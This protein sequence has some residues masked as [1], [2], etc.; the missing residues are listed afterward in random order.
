[1]GAHDYG[2]SRWPGMQI[3]EAPALKSAPNPGAEK[4]E[5]PKAV[6][7]IERTEGHAPVVEAEPKKK[8][9]KHK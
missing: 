7:R 9:K 6:E 3:L 2:V 1:M 8:S 5:A 4:D